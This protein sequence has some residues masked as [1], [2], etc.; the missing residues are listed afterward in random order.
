MIHQVFQ[1]H[2]FADVHAEFEL[3]AHLAEHF[4]AA[5]HHLFFQLKRG[6]AEGQQAADFR[7]A[8]VHG[9]VHTVA[10][11]HVGTAQT[12]RPGTDYRHFFTRFR[13]IAHLRPPAHFKGFFGDVF[14]HIADG[15]RAKLGIQ[16][17]IAFAQT[18][19][20]AHAAAHFRQRVGAVRQFRRLDNAPFVGEL[21]PVGD[22]VVQRAFILAIRIATRQTTV[23]LRL[24]LSIGKRLINFHKR[25]FART[26]RDFRRIYTRQVDKL[27][28]IFLGHGCSLFLWCF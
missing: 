26:Q 8:F 24:R 5:A 25:R 18:V 6:N 11:Q 7:L 4:T 27:V 12:C 9:H 20:R 16:R 2:I 14:F 3:N 28:N 15:D 23:G 19:L 13:H 22:I 1:R 10:D 17:A 21:Q